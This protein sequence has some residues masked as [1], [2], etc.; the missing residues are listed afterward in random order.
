MPRLAA[1]PFDIDAAESLARELNLS[2]PT[3]VALTRRG[4]VGGEAA[5]RFI[6]GDEIK[7]AGELA[8]VDAAVERIREAMHSGRSISVF[9]D[10]DVDGVCGTSIL[11]GALRRLGADCDWLIPDRLTDGYGLR[12]EAVELLAGRGTGLLITVD[13][14]ITAVEEVA[15]AQGLGLEVIVTDHHRP[16]ERLPECLTI[17]PGV[18][19]YATP[20]LCGAAVAWKLATA[21]GEAIGAEAG[22]EA[23]LDLVALA[24]V[25]D[26]VPLTGENRSLVK[27]GL[28]VARRAAR[29][30]LRELMKVASCRPAALD[31]SDLGFRLGPRVNAVGRLYRAD[32]GVELFL[33]QDEDR[34]RAV[35]EELDRANRERRQ[36]E[37]IVLG[38]AETALRKIKRESGMPAG[39][40]VAG[41]G[42]HPGVIGIVASRLVEQHG[43][44]AVVVSIEPG[45]MARGSGRGI[46][47]FDLLQAL[48]ECDNLLRRYGG[49]RAAAGLE[50]EAD[51]LADFTA[52]FS[53]AAEKQLGSDPPVPEL[54]IDAFAS[55]RELGLDLADELAQLAPFGIGNPGVNLLVPGAAISDPTPLGADRSHLRFTVASGG[56]KAKA[57]AFG[58]STLGVETGGRADLLMRLERNEWNGSIEPRLRLLDLVPLSPPEDSDLYRP[59]CSED[60]WWQ[61]FQTG[62]RGSCLDPNPT[63]ATGDSGP[64]LPRVGPGAGPAVL[65][66]LLA[67]GRPTLAVAADAGKRARLALGPDGH[68]RFSGGAAAV[69]SFR[70][71]RERFEA[72]LAADFGLIDFASLLIHAGCKPPGDR[73]QV[74][75]IDPPAGRAELEAALAAAQAGTAQALWDEPARRF[76]LHALAERSIGRAAVASTY[77]ALR[78]AADSPNPSPRT[79]LEGNASLPRSPEQAGL[80]I[81]VLVELGLVEVDAAETETGARRLRVVSSNKTDLDRSELFRRCRKQYEVK[82]RFLETHQ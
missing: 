57:I 30:G 56:Y 13:C 20:G 11:V 17:H 1:A 77:R 29:P 9:G 75:L 51:R 2:R 8:G 71:G 10:F 73:V 76:A 28:R 4:I 79:L 6:A 54:R 63:P 16:G 7:P 24:T 60:E 46:P 61:R 81:G 69:A 36:T 70:D 3:A 82:A 67:C 31:E 34:A 68:G 14:G 74:V 23:D 5:R 42:W 78:E 27:H 47:G 72:A 41:Q 35:A 64:S 40:M 19:G 39:I 55:G 66:E 26:L 38:E 49:H 37:L 80:C 21:L 50:L 53:A 45:G 44:P 33:T 52:A 25:A 43:R 15:F 62:L 65:A 48:L 59:R 22:G 18:S 32:A 58:R 12:R